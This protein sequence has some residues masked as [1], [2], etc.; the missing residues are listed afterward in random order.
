MKKSALK[1]LDWF[2][3]SKKSTSA[4][5][6][7]ESVDQMP[8]E[9]N[10]Q[11]APGSP[12]LSEMASADFVRRRL[13]KISEKTEKTKDSDHDN[14]PDALDED[15]QHPFDIF[16]RGSI[17]PPLEDED[18]RDPSSGDILPVTKTQLASQGVRATTE[19]SNGINGSAAQLLAVKGR[20]F[21]Y[22]PRDPLHWRSPLGGPLPST[23]QLASAVT[24]QR[25]TTNSDVQN[26]FSYLQRQG[27]QFD[28]AIS[29]TVA[30]DQDHFLIIPNKQDAMQGEGFK[31]NLQK[32]KGSKAISTFLLAQLLQSR[33]PA[34]VMYPCTTVDE[35][36]KEHPNLTVMD[37]VERYHEYPAINKIYPSLKI[38]DIMVI[39][40]ADAKE[41]LDEAIL[42]KRHIFKGKKRHREPL[43]S[44]TASINEYGNEI[45]TR[46]EWRV[47]PESSL[48]YRD[49]F[50]GQNATSGPEASAPA[51][52][53]GA[54][55][56]PEV[57]WLQGPPGETGATGP[58]GRDGITVFVPVGA[59]E[60]KSL[61]P[62]SQPSL[63]VYSKELDTW[64]PY[65]GSLKKLKGTIFRITDGNDRKVY[66][67]S[68]LRGGK[69]FFNVPFK[70]EPAPRIGQRI[71]VDITNDQYTI[72]NPQEAFQWQNKQW[73]P[74]DKGSL[75]G[76]IIKIQPE[77]VY[78]KG[79]GTDGKSV[80]L[81]LPI[82]EGYVGNT[83]IR[84]LKNVFDHGRREFSVVVQDG[85][86]KVRSANRHRSEAFITEPG[87]MDQP[88]SRASQLAP[89]KLHIPRRER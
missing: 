28:E 87:S 82:E 45:P 83:P 5:K 43:G 69:I 60:P 79:K 64:L 34:Q 50:S 80:T 85:I 10:E 62:S 56:P 4:D 35:Y 9:N 46:P 15:T 20:N 22:S 14:V 13:S 42:Q 12:T 59:L 77:A 57:R 88:L 71:A 33:I 8:L 86:C 1:L 30:L 51:P 6:K 40:P 47:T 67:A 32:G 27:R 76:T 25:S 37:W 53:P 11:V 17:T 52:Q 84:R 81:A 49:F 41:I 70:K 38:D 61:Q 54:P 89:S 75:N 68:N 21:A 58:P 66:I 63:R 73:S 2:S 78:F 44:P 24:I 55:I 23:T 18:I 19:V 29:I 16:S 7:S 39:P 3:F 72:S 74:Y 48:T 65:E 31:Y 36:M 26:L